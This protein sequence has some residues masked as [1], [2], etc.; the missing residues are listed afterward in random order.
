MKGIGAER[1]WDLAEREE[2]RQGLEKGGDVTS[3]LTL[4]LK[5]RV[6]KPLRDDRR[7]STDS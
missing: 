1:I 4:S 6:M 5:E 7:K 3:V 2:M